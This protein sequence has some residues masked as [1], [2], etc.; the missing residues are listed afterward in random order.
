MDTKRRSATYHYVRSRGHAYT[1]IYYEQARTRIRT[2]FT[3]VR[4]QWQ[5]RVWAGGGCR[6]ILLSHPGATPA[7]L[8]AK[9]EEVARDGPVN[10]VG[11]SSCTSGFTVA[12]MACST[13]SGMCDMDSSS[14][15]IKTSL[16]RL[17]R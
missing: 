17:L 14:E 12:C 10:E 16:K 5:L 13:A 9:A 3:W 15:E 11:S 6:N 1:F 8:L 7:P 2:G 4:R